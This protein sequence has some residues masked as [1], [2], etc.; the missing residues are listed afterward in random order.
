VIKLEDFEIFSQ[1]NIS[2]ARIQIV[3]QRRMEYHL[4]GSILQSFLLILI[5]FMTY[6]FAVDNFSDRIMVNLT[7]M[8]VLAT[9]NTSMSNVSI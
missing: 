6:F 8:L 5:G 1:R 7:T 3:F 9:I 4:T 2:K